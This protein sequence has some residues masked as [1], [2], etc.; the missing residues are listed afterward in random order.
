M[1]PLSNDCHL[2]LPTEEQLE[3]KSELKTDLETYSKELATQLILGQA[4]LDDWDS[5]MAELKD[6]GL[7]E[8]LEIEN[9][10]LVRFNDAVGK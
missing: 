5:Y 3:R 1:I 2:A 10:Q 8:I 7:D 4:S 6:L 9:D